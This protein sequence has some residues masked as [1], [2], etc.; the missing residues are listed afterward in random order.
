MFIFLF[1]FENYIKIWRGKSE[2]V[3]ARVIGES[4]KAGEEGL[5][6]ALKMMRN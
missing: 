2:L 5:N 6:W 1:K 4:F 3:K